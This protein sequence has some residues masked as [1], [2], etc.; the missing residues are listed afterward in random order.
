MPGKTLFIKI[1][2]PALTYRSKGLLLDEDIGLSLMQGIGSQSDC[3]GRHDKDLTAGFSCSRQVL[4]QRSYTI[5]RERALAVKEQIRSE[6]DNNPRS[7]ANA[8]PHQF[9]MARIR[10]SSLRCSSTCGR[11]LESG[12]PLT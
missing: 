12:A 11:S 7:V 1:H 10:R 2:Q 8:V 4:D 6:F 9:I 3:A 5:E